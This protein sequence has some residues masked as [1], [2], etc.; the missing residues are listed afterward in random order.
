MKKNTILYVLIVVLALIGV[1]IWGH[2]ELKV[3][4]DAI[5]FIVG[6]ILVIVI[7]GLIWSGF[8]AAKGKFSQKTTQ[9]QLIQKYEKTDDPQKR[10]E[11]VDQITNGD[12][13]ANI[14]VNDDDRNVRLRA[15]SHIQDQSVLSSI[16]E[17]DEEWGVRSAAVKKLTD[18]TALEKS[19]AQD[20]E[21]VVRAIAEERLKMINN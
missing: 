1:L 11:L 7:W 9:E 12:V 4:R 2:G 10:C 3:V 5:F 16:A 13:L 15:V 6:G 8:Y 18:R 14:A 17:R 20:P 19:A 21:R